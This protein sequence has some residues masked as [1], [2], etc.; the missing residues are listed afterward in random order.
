MTAK[1]KAEELVN[2]FYSKI[3]GMELSY[4]SKLIYLPNGD[5]NYET[6]KQCAIIAVDEILIANTFN[7]DNIECY[8]IEYKYYQE[9]RQE[10]QKL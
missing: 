7:K 9:V 5:S 3:T 2:K 1:E 6:A 4:I 8:L 10:I